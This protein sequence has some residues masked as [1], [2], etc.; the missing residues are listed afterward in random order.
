[1]NWKKRVTGIPAVAQWDLWHLCS[2]RTQVQSPASHR[3]LNNPVLWHVAT[4]SQVSSLAQELHRLQG[5]QKN[6]KINKTKTK[7]QNK[8]KKASYIQNSS[9]KWPSFFFFFLP[10]FGFNKIMLFCQGFSFTIKSADPEKA[11]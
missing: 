10:S 6:P 11:I 2:A 1:M 5:S 8:T 9:I 7:R 4:A 3:G